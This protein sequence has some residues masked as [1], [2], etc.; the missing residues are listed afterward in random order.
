M[1]T[2]YITGTSASTSLVKSVIQKA[3]GMYKSEE[4]AYQ[5][6]FLAQARTTLLPYLQQAII[7]NDMNHLPSLDEENELLMQVYKDVNDLYI[8]EHSIM[9][10]AD[11]LEQLY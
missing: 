7:K 8:D 3:K 4:I 5:G 10:Q 2:K 9:T 1:L 6:A 11:L